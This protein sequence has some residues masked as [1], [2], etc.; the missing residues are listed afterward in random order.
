ME[1]EF[2]ASIKLMSGEEIVAKVSY[3]KDDDVLII[4][5]PRLVNVIE[6]K[7]GKS[8]MKGFTFDAWMAATYDEMFIIKKDHILTITELDTKIK[9]FYT[10]FL[11][12]ENGEISYSSKVDI[13]HQ[14]GYMS[15]VKEARKSLED[16]Y[17][18]S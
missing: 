12:K 5:N 18:R 16:L 17:K 9:K 2:Y 10:R 6:M 13:K 7:R 14:R 8:N 11:Q 1:E 4:E 15:S 3:D